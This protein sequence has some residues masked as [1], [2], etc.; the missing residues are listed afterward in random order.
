VSKHFF[1]KSKGVK[2]LHPQLEEVFYNQP[3]TDTELWRE[4][5]RLLAQ[6]REDK[7]WK[8][9]SDVYDNKGRDFKGPHNSIVKRHE[10]GRISSLTTLAKHARV[11]EITVAD[12]LRSALEKTKE[13]LTP[14]ARGIARA[15][16]DIRDAEHQRMIAQLVAQLSRRPSGR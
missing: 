3:V 5:G 9:H 16:D 1:S 12:L 15:F 11:L 7:G 13:R 4:V 10:Q 6:A 2:G 14:R 8:H